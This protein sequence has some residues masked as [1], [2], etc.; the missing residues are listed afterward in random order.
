[1]TVVPPGPAFFLLLAGFTLALAI[2]VHLKAPAGPVTDYFTIFAISVT[3]WLAS[4]F[5]LYSN[6]APGWGLLWARAAFAAGA[7]LILSVYHVL[8]LF[9]DRHRAPFGS[10]V[11]CV[12]VTLAVL[13]IV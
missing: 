3:A 12:G 13:S 8:V 9:P 5:L 10:L 7:V 6:I 11:N 2:L 4:G 1:M